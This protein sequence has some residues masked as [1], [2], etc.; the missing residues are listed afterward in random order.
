MPLPRRTLLTAALLIAGVALSW[1]WRR[2]LALLIRLLLGG[3]AIAYLLHPLSQLFERRFRLPRS[4]SVIS[5]LLSLCAAAALLAV[6]FLP[7][8]IAQMRTLV[9]SLEEPEKSCGFICSKT[10]L[11]HW[12]P[13]EICHLLHS[14][15]DLFGRL[16][17]LVPSYTE[18]DVRSY[19]KLSVNNLYHELCHRFIHGE[20]GKAIAA[21]PALYQI[22][23]FLLQNLYYLEHGLF[24][25]TKAELLPLLSGRN[26]SV[27]KCAM[28][29]KADSDFDFHDCFELLFLW[30]QETL[31][32]L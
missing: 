1:L 11:S 9:S 16:R 2:Q 22:A 20:R 4:A 26:H 32:S 17:P 6:L 30:C 10:D 13:L 27:L 5:A 15:R 25:Q 12:N 21:L 29:F 28:T 18:Q 19:V 14:T 31:T 3:G 7:P 24:P 8:L 23:F